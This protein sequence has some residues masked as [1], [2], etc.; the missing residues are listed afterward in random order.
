VDL[1]EEVARHVGYDRLPAR[2]R[3]APPRVERDTTR[4]K[5]IATSSLLVGLGFHEIIAPSMVDPT[6]S[7]RF[8]ASPPVVLANPLSQDASAMRTSAVPSMLRAVR[9]N[10]DRDTTDV[11]LFELGKTYSMSSNG[12][13]EEQ[14]VLTLGATGYRRPASVYDDEAPLDI[15]DLKGDLE[16]I[17]GAFDVSAWAFERSGHTYLQPGCSGRMSSKGVDFAVFGLIQQDLARE[18]KLRQEVWVAEVNFERLLD[19]PFRSRKFQPIS[20]FPAVERDFSLVLPDDLPYARLSSAIAGLALEE[21]RHFRPVDRFRGGAIPPG[22]YS[23]LLRV[24]FQSQTHTL[25][26]EEVGG[27]SQRLLTTL[28]QLGVHLRG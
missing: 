25:T 16:T 2:V 26:S 24:T 28:Q 6:E 1:V 19:F 23:L 20:K 18:Y 12:V 11:R 13:P 14:R 10:L 17:L 4:D 8:S 27:L 5:V 21:I 3:P 9:W 15:F 22:H 7:E